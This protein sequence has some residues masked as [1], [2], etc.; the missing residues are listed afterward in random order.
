[1]APALHAARP[2]RRRHCPFVLDSRELRHRR[3]RARR[4]GRCDNGRRR[5]ALG[6]RV[7]ARGLP[8]AHVGRM[9]P[10]AAVPRDGARHRRRHAAPA[11]RQRR[12]QLDHHRDVGHVP[13][14]RRVLDR[15]DVPCRG[16]R[17][18]R[19][20][21]LVDRGAETREAAL[22]RLRAGPGRLGRMRDAHEV[23]GRHSG[24]HRLLGRLTH[25]RGQEPGQLG[26]AGRQLEGDEPLHR[27]GC[28]LRCRERDG[29][30]HRSE[31]PRD[32]GLLRPVE[33]QGIADD[34]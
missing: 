2:T 9:R 23:R 4:R 27:L 25:R 30:G 14:R 32:H 8:G 19:R 5:A 11:Q 33:Q 29:R 3:L 18:E 24:E 6:A 34:A 26:R 7:E 20:R 16:W 28:A 10:N 15:P 1:M 13:R 21:D 22:A 12:A 17:I 31:G